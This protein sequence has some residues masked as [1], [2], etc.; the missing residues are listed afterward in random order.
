MNGEIA[1]ELAHTLRQLVQDMPVRVIVDCMDGIQPKSIQMEFV[2][3]VYRVFDD[4][5][6]H[7]CG[8]L[9][10][11]L[12]NAESDLRATQK[13]VENFERNQRQ[14]RS[15]LRQSQNRIEELVGEVATLKAH[16]PRITSSRKSTRL[17][18]SS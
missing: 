18:E 13:V 1:S 4:E 7:Q 17:K 12:R 16:I 10:A 14:D 11:A 8:D 2:D 6:S 3:P 15:E 5:L 9:R